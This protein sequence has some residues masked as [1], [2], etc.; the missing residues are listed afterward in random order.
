MKLDID[1]AIF[2]QPQGNV[3]GV[4]TAMA[5]IEK[6]GK[7]KRF[8]LGHAYLMTDAPAALTLDVPKGTVAYADAVWLA[9]AMQQ[10]A[11]AVD[12]AVRR[13]DAAA[14]SSTTYPRRTTI[15]R[16]TTAFCFECAKK[17]NR[18]PTALMKSVWL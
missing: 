17:C 2:S 8:R 18:Q 3:R 16:R 7:P 11:E 10:F 12:A 6:N 5:Q 9:S 15:W 13:A 4:V 14:P 1:T